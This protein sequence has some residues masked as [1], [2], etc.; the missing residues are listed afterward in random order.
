MNGQQG[1]PQVP[2]IT[3][4]ELKQGLDR[5]DRVVLVDVREAFEK[6]IADLPEVGQR[7]IPVGEVLERVGELDPADRIVLYCRSGSRSGWATQQLQE[8]GFTDV[9]NLKGGVLA[10]REQVDPSLRAY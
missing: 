2:E 4:T 7:R 5:G 8:R 3:A 6:D 10:W 1:G 9:W